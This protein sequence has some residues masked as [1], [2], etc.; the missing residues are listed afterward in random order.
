MYTNLYNLL[1]QKGGGSEIMFDGKKTMS[2]LQD[3]KGLLIAILINFMMQL[4]ISYYVMNHNQYYN[5]L[6]KK[7]HMGKNIKNKTVK[8]IDTKIIDKYNSKFVVILLIL[9]GLILVLYFFDIP[10]YIKLIIFFLFSYIFGIILISLKYLLGVNFTETMIKGVLMMLSV[11]L[12]VNIVL[13]FIK[14]KD[15]QTILFILYSLLM[16]VF[17][18]TSNLFTLKTDVTYRM[19]T[20]F[21]L[22]VISIYMIYDTHNILQ[23]NYQ[24][25]FVT[26][27]LDYFLDIL[28]LI[29]NWF[30]KLIFYK[31]YEK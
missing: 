12:L 15:I 20:Y 31:N 9:F 17:T 1:I 10:S 29:N 7:K 4:S 6:L 28:K 18:I 16:I 3:K 23:R 5:D 24:N 11:F 22:F 13:F 8:N 26:A 21:T 27:S 25:D 19:I 14:I 2:Q 30:Q